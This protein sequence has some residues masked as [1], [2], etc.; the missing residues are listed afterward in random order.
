MSESIKRVVGPITYKWARRI[1]ISVMG[2]TVVLVG[3]AMIV[4]PGPALVVI[5]I[6]LGILG[7]EYAWARRWLKRL[8]EHANGIIDGVRNG[9]R[10]GRIWRRPA[11]GRP[12]PDSTP[13]VD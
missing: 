8:R 9:L 12:P 1:V 10:N 6:G 2:G 5:P 7:L 13:P 11:A 3:V 4:L